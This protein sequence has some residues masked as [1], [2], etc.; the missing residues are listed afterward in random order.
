MEQDR[1]KT[2]EDNRL[3]ME[4]S[5]KVGEG[6]FMLAEGRTRNGHTSEDMVS[7]GQ[8]FSTKKGSGFK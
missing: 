3:R 6:K 8:P 4:K 5:E 1:D 7:R 2:G